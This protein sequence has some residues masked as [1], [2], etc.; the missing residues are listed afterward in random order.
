MWARIIEKLGVCHYCPDVVV[1]HRHWST[2][3]RERDAI[4]VTSNDDD[5]VVKADMRR[6]KKLKK[7]D[8]VACIADRVRTLRQV[9]VDTDYRAA[10]HR[11]I[12]PLGQS[13]PFASLEN[14]EVTLYGEHYEQ[15]PPF[16]APAPKRN[17]L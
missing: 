9:A 3:K 8:E 7:N 2:G 12:F 17:P 15:C 11:A 10:A 14:G 5:E 13:E 4:D 6:Y 16:S 1:E